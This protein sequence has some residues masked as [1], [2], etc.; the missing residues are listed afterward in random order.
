MR[1]QFLF[2]IVVFF[3]KNLALVLDNCQRCAIIKT[4]MVEEIFNKKGDSANE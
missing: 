4:K 1:Q 3:I 2:R